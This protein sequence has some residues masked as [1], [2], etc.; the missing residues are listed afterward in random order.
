MKPLEFVKEMIASPDTQVSAKWKEKCIATDT[1]EKAVELL[2][3]IM[4]VY[5]RDVS[6]FVQNMCE[7]ILSQHYG[8]QILEQEVV[9][10]AQGNWLYP[11]AVTQ[12]H[13]VGNKYLYEELERR[14]AAV[15]SQNSNIEAA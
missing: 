1:E 2:I 7:F 14:K 10:D 12:V 3:D 15:R 4:L 6:D 8:N 11:V 9:R 13:A 5:G